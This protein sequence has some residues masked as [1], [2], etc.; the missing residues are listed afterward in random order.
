MNFIKLVAGIAA[1]ILL[2][3]FIAPVSAGPSLTYGISSS[4][5]SGGSSYSGR[6]ASISSSVGSSFVGSTGSPFL[7]YS[8]A[9]K[10]TGLRPTMGSMR[11]YA[12]ASSQTPGVQMSY[13]DSASASGIIYS[14]SK[15]Y[16]FY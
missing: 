14:F 8:V 16:T 13:S 15:V 7:G 1:L 11:V 9:A 10:G 2:V 5:Y 3:A 6:A 4:S 12:M